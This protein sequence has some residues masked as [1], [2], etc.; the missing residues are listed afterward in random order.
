MVSLGTKNEIVN[1]QNV[2]IQFGATPDEYILAWRKD[3]EY[4]SPQRR[5]PTGAGPI[6]FTMLPDNKMRITVAYT[7]GEIGTSVAS[8]F[9]EMI[10]RN[11]TTSEV[12]KNS[13]KMS[14]TDNA[15]GN[16][17]WT[18]NGKVTRLHVFAGRIGETIV[19]LDIQITDNVSTIT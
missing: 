15:G 1:A 16:N 2:L 5:V 12:P 18:H 10:K 13:W 14:F 6:Y 9:D 8:A 19:E 3:L 7:V 4:L 17:L 11:A